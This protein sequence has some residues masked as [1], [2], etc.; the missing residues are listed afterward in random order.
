MFGSFLNSVLPGL[1]PG[2]LLNSVV[3]L[4]TSKNPVASVNNIALMT[5]TLDMCANASTPLTQSKC[6]PGFVFEET[7]GLCFIVLNETGNYWTGLETCMKTDGQMVGFKNDLELQ[8]L[9]DLSKKG[10][11][12]TP[13]E[14]EQNVFKSIIAQLNT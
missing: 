4:F 6:N 14:S 3:Q 12:T 2:E 5:P 10:K 11:L 8:S 13:N 7:S 9:I 1:V